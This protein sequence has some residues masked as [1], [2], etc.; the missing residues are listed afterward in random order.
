MGIGEGSGG[1]SWLFSASSVSSEALLPTTELDFDDVLILPAHNSYKSRADVDLTCDLLGIKKVIPIIAANMDNIGTFRVEEIMFRN[2]M[3][4]AISKYTTEQEWLDWAAKNSNDLLAHCERVIY[5]I[6]AYKFDELDKF[7]DLHKTIPF[8]WLMIDAANGYSNDFLVFIDDVATRLA[9]TGI[10]VR[11]IAGNV[12]TRHGADKIS[13]ACGNPYVK[14]G[15]GSGGV[16]TT[17]IMTGIGRPQFSAVQDCSHNRPTDGGEMGPLPQIISDGGIKCPGDVV[18]A[19]VAGAKMV[20]VGSYFAGHDETGLQ[21]YGMSSR[22]AQTIHHDEV[23]NYRA[24]E[25]RFTNVRPRGPLQLT[26]YEMLGGLRS[27]CTYTGAK[28]L[29]DLANAEWVVVNRQ[30]NDS[31]QKYEI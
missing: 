22:H 21:F 3:M 14:V 16:C 9:K 25:G 2:N 19:F 6:G 12:C 18:K 7:I 27:A 8:Q 28:N 26:V 13:F 10:R 24:S 4:T 5:S 30:F 29:H 31:M 1:E 17:R 23:K 11:L 20:M 15:I